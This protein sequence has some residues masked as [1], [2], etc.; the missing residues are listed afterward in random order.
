M[1]YVIS[2]ASTKFCSKICTYVACTK[3]TND[4][5]IAHDT[6]HL[7]TFLFCTGHI[8]TFFETKFCICTRYNITHVHDLFHIFWKTL[9]MTSGNRL[10][11]QLVA[12]YSLSFFLPIN[13]FFSYF[14]RDFPLA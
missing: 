10:R 2:W 12:E 4:K 8:C 5:S 11:V 7:D 6:I 3:K 9:N 13:R 14:C 1:G